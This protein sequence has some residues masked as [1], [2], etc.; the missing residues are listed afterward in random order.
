MNLQKIGRRFVLFKNS[1]LKFCTLC[2]Q[3]IINEEI[4]IDLITRKFFHLG[5]FINNL[6]DLILLK[7]LKLSDNLALDVYI[8]LIFILNRQM[9]ECKKNGI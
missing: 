8:L 2:G 5:C 6:V 3:K 1:K 4:L 7:K 9:V